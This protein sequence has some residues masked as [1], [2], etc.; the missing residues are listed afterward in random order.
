MEPS[1]TP[2]VVISPRW[3]PASI[4]L[5]GPK[6]GR[7]PP[8][9]PPTPLRSPQRAGRPHTTGKRRGATPPG[10]HQGPS[11]GGGETS[12]HRQAT[13][14][15]IEFSVST[16][17]RAGGAR[18]WPSTWSRWLGCCR[19]RRALP[20][21]LQGDD[22]GP[23]EADRH[24]RGSRKCGATTP[25]GSCGPSSTW[26]P[27]IPPPRHQPAAGV[28]FGRVFVF[29]HEF[30]LAKRQVFATTGDAMNLARGSWQVRAGQVWATQPCCPGPQP[31]DTEDIAPFAVK[32]KSAPV[33]ASIV[34]AHASDAR[35]DRRRRSAV[36]RREPEYRRC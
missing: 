10:R 29:S 21:E 32:G 34:V 6:K 27:T 7:C 17:C 28:N 3:R 19:R 22:I 4:P 14:A 23:T 9:R 35:S 1:P 13:V 33:S 20:G 12:E 15:F 30:D 25:S 36:R 5:L 18:W 26:S 2:E 16:R 31:F 24:R 11:S 8:R